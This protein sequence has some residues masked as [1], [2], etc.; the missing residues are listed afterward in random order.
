M[1]GK[2]GVPAEYLAC[3]ALSLNV[4]AMCNACVAVTRA[5]PEDGELEWVRTLRGD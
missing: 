4:I 5:H 3:F 1:V 2:Q